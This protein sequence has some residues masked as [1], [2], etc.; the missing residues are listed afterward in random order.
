MGVVGYRAEAGGR[1]EAI[2]VNVQERIMRQTLEAMWFEGILDSDMSGSEWRTSG[3][4]SSGDSV[5]YTCEA[6]RKFSFGRVKVKKGS[7]QREGVP[8]TDLDL[9]LEE[10]VLNSLK[11]ANVTAFI[12]ELLETMAKDSQCRAILPLNIPLE[13]RHYDALESHMTDGHLYHPSYKSRLGF[14]LKDNL[15]YGPEFNSEVSLVWVA[16]KKELA[17]TAVSAGY[18]S[19]ELVRQHLTAEDVERFQEVLE[20][21][22]KTGSDADDRYVFIPVHPWQWEHQLE[23]VYARQL[24]DGDIV[25]L[26]PSSSPYRAQQSIR[27][28]SNRV[29]PE[30]PYIKLAL[31]ITNTSSTR[32]LAQHTTQNAPLISD[33]LDNLVREDEL[34]QRAQFGLL[35][36][37]MGLSFR[38]EQLPATQY[39]RAY[40]TLGGIWRE[41]V[42]VHLKQG[43]TAWPLNALMLVQ[44]DGVPFIQD[45]VERHGVEKWSEALVRTVTLPIIHLLYA[46]GIALESHA[47]NII[48]VLEDD[49]P[50]RIIIKD[51]HDGVRYV[52]DQLLHPERAP[53]LNPEPETHRKFNRYS[54]IY[55]EDVS[56]VRDYTYDAFFF[57]CMTDI[58]LAFEKFGLSEQSFW[59]LCAGVIVNYQ[60]QHPE[61]AERFVAFDLFAEDA[62]IEE[63]TKRRLYGDGELYFRKASNPLKVSKD[64]LESQGTLELKGIVE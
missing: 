54:F 33:W 11:G 16:V 46:H 13:D 38:Y 42:S 26:G 36:E 20:G 37:I 1:T 31:S 25:Y 57:I 58:A 59:Q 6:E 32:I 27:S 8:C 18:S 35:K 10:I 2:Y 39:G 29:N 52:P 64:A 28:L 43:E 61:Y 12:Q 53:K 14:S 3:L 51:L 5:A 45:A 49:L 55:A 47:Q 44:A 24:M 63:M 4:T 7:I 60:K 34:L 30:A 56:E 9:F 17:Q 15:A 40:G 41:N 19:E 21:D 22:G 48:L 50:K 62:L 23:S